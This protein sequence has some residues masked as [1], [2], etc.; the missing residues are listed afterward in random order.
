MSVPAFQSPIHR[1]SQD[2]L[3][4]IFAIYTH[5]E[6]SE[7][8]GIDLYDSELDASDL[9]RKIFALSISSSPPY[10]PYAVVTEHRFWSSISLEADTFVVLPYL[11]PLFMHYLTLSNGA[12]LTLRFSTQSRFPPGPVQE[13]FYTLL[14]H[15]STWRHVELQL[16]FVSTYC[17]RSILQRGVDPDPGW[18]TSDRYQYTVLGDIEEHHIGKD[19]PDL[20][21]YFVGDLMREA[22][23]IS[24]SANE[25][26]LFPLLETLTLKLKDIRPIVVRYPIVDIL[27]RMPALRELNLKSFHVVQDDSDLEKEGRNADLHSLSTNTVHSGLE[28]FSPSTQFPSNQITSLSLVVTTLDSFKPSSFDAISPGVKSAPFP[29]LKTLEL[30]SIGMDR[31]MDRHAMAKIM[32]PSIYKFSQF[33][34]GGSPSEGKV[35]GCQLKVFKVNDIP[36]SLIIQSFLYALPTIKELVFISPWEHYAEDIRP[37][38][39]ELSLPN[40]GS[41]SRMSFRV[42]PKLRS[43]KLIDPSGLPYSNRC[44]THRPYEPNVTARELEQEVCEMVESR[45]QAASLDVVKTQTPTTVTLEMYWGWADV[46]HARLEPLGRAGLVKGNSHQ[47]FIEMRKWKEEHQTRTSDN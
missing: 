16:G 14:K 1:L 33:L 15:S 5:F 46:I 10:D 13:V 2:I 25:V 3:Y 35:G 31:R 42:L 20:K 21:T 24:N 41:T 6:P 47:R 23:G 8:R 38:M 36:A 27:S 22:L 29:H 37:L 28:V 45:L 7:L 32:F 44:G 11:Q 19:F 26:K 17:I 18:Y 4:E 34:L 9:R 12:P 43:L 40:L 39:T 30:H